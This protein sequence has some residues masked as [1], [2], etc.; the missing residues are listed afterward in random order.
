MSNWISQTSSGLAKNVT[1]PPFYDYLKYRSIDRARARARVRSAVT[2]AHFTGD[3]DEISRDRISI[4]TILIRSRVPSSFESGYYRR[5]FT[6]R[7]TTLKISDRD[8]R[9]ALLGTARRH[10][11]TRRPG[12]G[13]LT[14]ML[15]VRHAH[16]DTYIYIVYMRETF[17]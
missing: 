10:E 9:C 1:S 14:C 12:A 15:S 17:N 7:Y 11:A 8:G 4:R 5:D 2:F 13:M 3:R 6:S 16:A